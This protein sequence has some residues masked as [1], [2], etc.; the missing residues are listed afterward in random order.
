MTDK[1]TM[2]SRVKN[3]RERLYGKH[4]LT[5]VDD[6]V[7]PAF[8]SHNALLKPGPEGYKAFAQGFH[9]G[10][11]D[12]RPQLQ[13]VLVHGDRVVTFT[14]WEGTHTGAFRDAAP[15]GNRITFETADLFRVQDGRFIEHWDVVDRLA[16]M[17][18]LGL[19]GSVRELSA[20]D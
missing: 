20:S 12:L 3:F 4:D 9:N 10:L 16:A 18:G 1:E 7:H 17:R 2:A 8:R 19:V 5:A 15:T 11:P 14:H 6:Y 13:H